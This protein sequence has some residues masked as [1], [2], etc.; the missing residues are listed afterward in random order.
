M[1][2]TWDGFDKVNA[3]AFFT[4]IWNICLEK[5]KDKYE[6]YTFTEVVRQWSEE[7][8]DYNN[9]KNAGTT[10]SEKEFK[11]KVKEDVLQKFPVLI[12]LENMKF[13]SEINKNWDYEK[14]ANGITAQIK[15]E[16]PDA[17]KLKPKGWKEFK[18]N[19]S[20][21]AGQAEFDS[22]AAKKEFGGMHSGTACS[23]PFEVR[24]ALPYVMYDDIN[25]GR[26]PLNVLV[27][28]ILTHAYILNEK[29]NAASMLKELVELK[30]K[31]DQSEYYKEPVKNISFDFKVPL[32]KKLFT[33]MHNSNPDIFTNSFSEEID[34]KK[35]KP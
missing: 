8:A 9:W 3:E 7:R 4:Q 24:V 20:D 34:K 11:E 13:S 28:A 21:F 35:A 17:S 29:N 30:A 22:K 18:K 6:Q 2:K 31:Y 5:T 27:S 19:Y 32:N 1:V 25:H 16:F 26:K 33:M 10:I 15:K 23:H 14:V 12:L